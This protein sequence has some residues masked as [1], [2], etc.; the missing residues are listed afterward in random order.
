MNRLLFL[1]IVKW[2]FSRSR[3]AFNVVDAVLGLV[4]CTPM[5]VGLVALHGVKFC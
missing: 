5:V 2:Q 3:S 1:N 4:G